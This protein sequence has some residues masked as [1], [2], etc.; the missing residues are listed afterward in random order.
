MDLDPISPD[1]PVPFVIRLLQWRVLVPLALLATLLAAGAWQGQRALQRWR[2]DRLAAKAVALLDRGQTQEAS[3]LALQ[4]LGRNPNHL[5]ACRVMAEAHHEQNSSDALAWRARVVKLQPQSL[6]ARLDWAGEAVA[7]GATTLANDIL[8]GVAPADRTG[9]EYHE[10]AAGL[11][12]AVRQLG[13]AH[14]HLQAALK[15]APSNPRLRLNL[16]TLELGSDRKEVVARARA[17]LESLSAEP[18]VRLLAL[19]ALLADALQAR[20]LARAGEL[21]KRLASAPGATFRDKLLHLGVLH[22]ANDPSVPSR[23][24]E[25]QGVAAGNS[26]DAGEMIAWMNANGMAAQAIAWA[27]A[28]P[29]GVARTMPAPITLSES[30]ALSRDWDGL[31]EM[32]APTQ[33]GEFEPLRLAIISRAYRETGNEFGS[34]FQW[35][36]AVRLAFHQ[37]EML[38]ALTRFAAGWGWQKESEQLLWDLA[39]RPSP[40]RAVLETLY[41]HY[42]AHRDLKGLRRVTQRIVQVDPQDLAALNNL[43]LF[44]LLA[45]AELDDAFKG[46]RELHARFPDNPAFASTHAFALHRRGHTAEGIKVLEALP[47]A[48]LRAP[49]VAVYYGILLAAKGDKPRAREFLDLG[50]PA[51][52]LPAE[53]A[54]V[55]E[56]RRRVQ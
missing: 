46:A 22:R 42:Q 21:G 29:P 34:Q 26:L 16:A 49:D 17:S 48:A 10:I 31:L 36:T 45:N 25:L 23:L 55:A 8:L 2:E 53:E 11:A 5:Q 37:P 43:A 7:R 35:R 51:Q 24:A 40:P 32:L 4:V 12:I 56:A 44:S 52:L 19:R 9:V 13:L 18:E 30:H 38:N 15:R 1:P 20:D 28:L 41:R 50:A 39:G 6:R 47:P 33:W 14:L 54:L 27:R 3:F